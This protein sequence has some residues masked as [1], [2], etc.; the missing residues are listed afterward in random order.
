MRIEPSPV[1][2]SVPSA[3]NSPFFFRSTWGRRRVGVE[4]GVGIGRGVLGRWS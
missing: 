3:L 4:V 2:S 1:S